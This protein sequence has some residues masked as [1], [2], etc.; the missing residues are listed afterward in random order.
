MLDSSHVRFAGE[1]GR[2]IAIITVTYIATG[3]TG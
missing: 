2:E 1:I 3:W